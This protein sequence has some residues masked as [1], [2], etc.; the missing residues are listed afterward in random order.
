MGKS[1]RK[2]DLADDKTSSLYETWRFITVFTTAY[3]WIAL[4]TRKLLDP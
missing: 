1:L 2:T 4:R 3:H